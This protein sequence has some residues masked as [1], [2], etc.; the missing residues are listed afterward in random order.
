MREDLFLSK[1]TELQNESLIK[2]VFHLT[3][4]NREVSRVARRSYIY[5]KSSM[6]YDKAVGDNNLNLVPLAGNQFTMQNLGLPAK[7]TH[8][9]G[10]ATYNYKEK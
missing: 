6:G 5:G 10:N 8:I 4:L 2:S 9:M 7:D 1:G 3:V